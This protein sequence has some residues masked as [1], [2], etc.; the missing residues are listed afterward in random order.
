MACYIATILA[1]F[2]SPYTIMVSDFNTDPSILHTS[3]TLKTQTEHLLIR[4]PEEH[5]KKNTREYVVPA[6]E[7]HLA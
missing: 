4:S 5:R 7:G 6:S 3:A 1:S 2:Q